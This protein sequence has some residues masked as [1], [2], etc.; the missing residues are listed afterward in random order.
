MSYTLAKPRKAPCENC[1]VLLEFPATAEKVSCPECE[2]VSKFKQKTV[3]GVV[4][5]DKATSAATTQGQSFLDK[6]LCAAASL[7]PMQ[8]LFIGLQ[9]VMLLMRMSMTK[10][11]LIKATVRIAAAIF[12]V[13]GK[14][15]FA[16]IGKIL[17]F[18]FPVLLS[19]LEWG[20]SSF[21]L[22]V[23]ERGLLSSLW[24]A[25][26]PSW[27]GLSS[28]AG[29]VLRNI[30][31]YIVCWQLYKW[32]WSNLVGTVRSK[33]LKLFTLIILP[34]MVLPHVVPAFTAAAFKQIVF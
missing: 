15:H 30:V 13:S 9:F 11:W 21:F 7:S 16:K 8:K 33:L 4:T 22:P 2:W 17:P 20:H 14:E 12:G 32:M 18:A 5:G 29:D 3:P 23:V 25:S 10:S 27:P 28:Y 24:F 6:R 26:E 34:Y 1:F 19:V 31:H